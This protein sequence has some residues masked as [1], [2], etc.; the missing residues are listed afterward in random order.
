MILQV[1]HLVTITTGQIVKLAKWCHINLGI[2]WGRRNYFQGGFKSIDD[3]ELWVELPF[4]SYIGLAVEG[5]MR[6]LIG[7][8]FTLS[9]SVSALNDYYENKKKLMDFRLGIG[10]RFGKEK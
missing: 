4:N 1:S 7:R 2:G 3:K 9:T 5:G 6:F 8:K 10:Y